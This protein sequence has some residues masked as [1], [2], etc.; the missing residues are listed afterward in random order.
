M[1]AAVRER[2]QPGDGRREVLQRDVC[3]GSA[4]ENRVQPDP[5]HS[6]SQ[7]QPTHISRSVVRQ[8]HSWL[9]SSS[10]AVSSDA[11]LQRPRAARPRLLLS[12]RR[13]AFAAEERQPG[14]VQAPD[15]P[16]LPEHSLRGPAASAP[17]APA[18]RSAHGPV[19]VVPRSH[20]RL[21]GNHSTAAAAPPALRPHT[22]LLQLSPGHYCKQPLP[23]TPA[24]EVDS[25]LPNSSSFEKGENGTRVAARS[26]ARL[27]LMW[28]CFS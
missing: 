23:S 8:P 10:H 4:S 12:R 11:S 1:P 24:V 9:H 5:L 22:A 17:P 7:L 16:A 27:I 21:R 26:A 25:L 13:E 14:Q 2:V 18:P 20:A 3:P 15:A 28:R 6:V 19:H